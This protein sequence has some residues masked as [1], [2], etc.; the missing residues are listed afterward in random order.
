MPDAGKI[1]RCKR[2]NKET[3]FNEWPQGRYV[4]LG[5]ILT[6]LICGTVDKSAHK[7]SGQSNE[8][9]KLRVRVTSRCE[10]GKTHIVVENQELTEVAVTFDFSLSNLVSSVTFPYTATFSPGQTRSEEHT[11]ELQS[12]SNLVCR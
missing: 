12:Q 6:V 5:L 4:I 9:A 2:V 10:G 1:P 11:S 7:C 8:P 3:T